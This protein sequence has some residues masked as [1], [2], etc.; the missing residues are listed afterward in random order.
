M[1]NNM[2]TCVGNIAKML[3][4]FACDKPVHTKPNQTMYL[5]TFLDGIGD[6]FDTVHLIDYLLTH[7]LREGVLSYPRQNHRG[8]WLSNFRSAAL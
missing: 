4:S 1:A 8:V 5:G 2:I 3:G 6:W 7:H